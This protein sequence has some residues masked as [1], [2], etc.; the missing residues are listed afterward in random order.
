MSNNKQTAVEWLVSQ[1]QNMKIGNNQL[2]ITDEDLNYLLNQAKEME[3]EQKNNLP[4]HIHE[5]IKNTW[6]YIEDGIVHVTP[7]PKA[8]EQQ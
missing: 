4:I 7:N 8:N 3:K 6:V 1:I 5:G 2:L